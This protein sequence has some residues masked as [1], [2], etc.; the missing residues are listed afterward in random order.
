MSDVIT[1]SSDNESC[2][3]AD[4]GK[5]EEC[6]KLNCSKSSCDGNFKYSSKVICMRLGLELRLKEAKTVYYILTIIILRLV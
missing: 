3:N 1:L 2:S 4:D 5:I 6:A